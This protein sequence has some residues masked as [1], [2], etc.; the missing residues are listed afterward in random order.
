[1]LGDTCVDEYHYGVVDR[2]SPE[3]PVPIFKYESQQ[4]RPGMAGNVEQNLLAL[5][6]EVVSIFGTPSKKVRL[7]DR[8]SKQHIARIDHDTVSEP[9]TVPQ[10]LERYDAVIVSDYDKGSIEYRTIKR[11]RNTF[12]GPIFADTKKH[13]LDK[14][15][16]CFVKVNE[17]E[18]SRRMSSYNDTIVTRGEKPVL[19]RDIQIPVE[20]VEVNDVC[21]AGDTFTAALAVKYIETNDVIESIKFAV[22]AA[23]VT[24][25][26]F[27]VYA[28]T[29]E[30]IAK[31]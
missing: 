17:L 7:I 26:H 21:G 22:A 13:H 1:M 15:E 3:A 2:I 14:F 25:Q 31:Q 11:I 4:S 10:N 5:G 28:P 9:V 29:L 18:Y 8:K 24:V 19:Y 6:C 12:S 23:R 16:G 30:E 20:P 27:G